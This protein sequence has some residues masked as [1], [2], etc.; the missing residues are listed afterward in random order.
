MDRLA[1][2]RVFAL[3][4]ATSLMRCSLLFPGV[5]GSTC[6]KQNDYCEPKIGFNFRS[7]AADIQQTANADTRAKRF[8][9]CRRGEHAD[10]DRYH[11]LERR[12]R[13]MWGSRLHGIYLLYG[14]FRIETLSSVR[15]LTRLTLGCALRRRRGIILRRV[16]HLLLAV[17]S[18]RRKA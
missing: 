7:T 13:A 15:V 6:V 18:S 14:I 12:V 4:I 17:R 11:L 5:S 2:S 1:A 10:H 8:A 16:E 3:D 9:V